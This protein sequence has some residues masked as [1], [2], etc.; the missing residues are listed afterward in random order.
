MEFIVCQ[1]CS[2]CQTFLRPQTIPLKA[3]WQL[4]EG[5]AADRNKARNHLTLGRA[6]SCLPLITRRA[7]RWA[8]AL[9]R[10]DDPRQGNPEGPSAGSPA[11]C[12]YALGVAGS[13]ITIQSTSGPFSESF[14]QRAPV[15][16][17]RSSRLR[18]SVR[19]ARFFQPFP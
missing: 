9:I 7:K 4:W 6:E 5:A 13:R 12:R 3:Q 16:A 18:A 2:T 1:T 15:R 19:R 11:T 17:S 10:G 14:G 8:K